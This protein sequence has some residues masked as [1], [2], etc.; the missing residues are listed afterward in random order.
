MFK[1]KDSYDE[2]TFLTPIGFSENRTA[3]VSSCVQ[4][5]GGEKVIEANSQQ[6]SSSS[7]QSKIKLSYF[8]QE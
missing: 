4:S 3:I 6:A 1:I 2:K 8:I 7:D 5:I